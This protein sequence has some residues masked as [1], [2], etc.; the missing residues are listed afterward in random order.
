MKDVSFNNATVEETKTSI[1]LTLTIEKNGSSYPCAYRDICNEADTL[2]DIY[3][4][5]RYDLAIVFI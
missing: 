2:F 4:I 5:D 1:S 3:K